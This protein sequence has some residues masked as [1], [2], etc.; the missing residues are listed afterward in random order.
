MTSPRHVGSQNSE[1][2]GQ[3]SADRSQES[4]D[5]SQESE[6]RSQ[7]E[8]DSVL[9]QAYSHGVSAHGDLGLAVEDFA[10]HLNSIIRKHL[11]AN[12][13][14]DAAVKFVAGLNAEDLYLTA[15]CV[16]N[17]ASA[18]SRF[19]ALYDKHIDNVAHGICSTHQEARELASSLMAHLFFHD[20]SERSRIASYDGR[21]SL[22][23]W[24]ATIIKHQVINQRQL[25]SAEAVPLD[26]LRNTASASA[27]S[28]FEAA[29][30]RNKYRE[31]IA[32][33]FKAAAE[34][35]SE[36]ER[37]VLVLRFEDEIA[38][39]EIAQLLGVHPSQI[40]RTVKSAQ[41][42]FRTTVLA[43]LSTHHRL[44]PE[45]I[46]E[47]VAEIF[48]SHGLSVIWCLRLP[49][50]P[51]QATDTAPAPQAVPASLLSASFA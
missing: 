29:L 8:F 16:H 32:D 49:E 48:G 12:P 28:E 11:G 13:A 24:L 51:A 6:V 38:A 25:K 39:T 36:R 37:L 2:R 4:E 10:A 31:A 44:G 27:A 5:R 35:L 40:T 7:D 47:C 50:R 15:A 22:R 14:Q 1:D 43:R 19:A 20:R 33:S 18:W 23:T 42:K 46:E 30:L 34:Q 9:E 26:S 41:V 45:A 3:E 21:G 17:S